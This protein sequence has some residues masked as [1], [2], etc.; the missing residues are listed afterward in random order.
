MAE[1]Q[2][3]VEVVLWITE[4][5]QPLHARLAWRLLPLL[6]GMLFAQGRR[7]VASWLRGGALS[8]DYTAYY[9]FLGSLGHK[10]NPIAGCLL[11]RA[12]AVI[13]PGERLLLALDDTPTKRYGPKVEGA[14]IHHNPTPGPA[15]QKFLY[16]HIWVT[17]AWVVRHAR[18]GTIG[19]P[20]L[21]LLYVR[22]KQS[23]PL[24]RYGVTFRTKLAMAA[25]LVE[26]AVSWLRPCG[27]ELWVVADGA[28]A[29][30]P[31]LKRALAA[32]VVVV[33]RLRRDAALR[34]L[35]ETPRRGQAKKRGRKPKYGKKA[36]S[37]AKRAA[38]RQGWLTD[39]FVLYGDTVTK[40][41]KTFLATYAPAGGV[42]RVVL[43][44]EDDGWV[45]YFCTRPEATVAQLLEAVADRGAI[46][47]DFHDLKE[48]HG[49]GQQQVRHY[50]SNIA[51]YHL[52][53]WL[54]TLIELWA[55]RRSQGQLCDRRLSP[56]DDPT[57][58]PSHA[59]RR[60]ALRR[61]CLETEIQGGGGRR[62]LAPKFRRLVRRLLQLVA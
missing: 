4:L 38:H 39:R 26:W 48:V 43:V 12:V 31:F 44:R 27:K 51:V 28:Y 46:E 18:F 11:R 22:Q 47:Q 6:A 3:P 1:G 21:A 7:T 5:A 16:G 36:I 37:L 52:N 60:K 56:W 20:L 41:Y 34:T 10:V 45:A 17:L 32:G 35:P 13:G 53:L 30:R 55:W 50:W 9:Y 57:R 25:E 15:A 42:I 14:G 40:T 23:A 2:L 49:A 62:R 54:H 59:D 24:Q 19:L 29:K 8:Q 61:Q 33:S 58:R